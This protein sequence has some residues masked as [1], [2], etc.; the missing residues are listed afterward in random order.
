MLEAEQIINYLT[1]YYRV[2]SGKFVDADEIQKWGEILSAELLTVFSFREE[3]CN[4]ALRHWAEMNGLDKVAIDA[5]WYKPRVFGEIYEPKKRNRFILH[6]PEHFVIQEWVISAASRPSMYIE[7]KK[8]LGFTISKKLKW[9]PINIV[10]LDPIAPST[11][12]ELM[13][14]INNN[15]ILEKFKLRVELLDPTG[16]V[17]ERWHIKDCQ[18]KSIDFGELNYA[19][20]EL[21]KCS[22]IVD[23][24]KVELEF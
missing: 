20:D 22:M 2:V 23:F 8:F 16:V 24:N 9:H 15:W 10:L 19:T 18:I 5:I 4:A 6:F 11:S 1:R 21:A 7:T 3:L 12:Q 13:T 14:I 17:V